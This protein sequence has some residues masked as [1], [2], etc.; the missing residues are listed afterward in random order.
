MSI[1]DSLGAASK[2][3]YLSFGTDASLYSGFLV[4]GL[5]A[6][7]RLSLSNPKRIGCQS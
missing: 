7:N 6:L 2:G 1:G 3:S 4:V 5:T